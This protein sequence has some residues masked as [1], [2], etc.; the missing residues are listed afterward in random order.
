ML[1]GHTTGLTGKGSESKK[2][3]TLSISLNL[4][5]TILNFIYAHSIHDTLASLW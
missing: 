2:I 5:L 1:E 4:S 3:L